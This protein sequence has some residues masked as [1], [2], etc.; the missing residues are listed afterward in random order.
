MQC[1]YLANWGKLDEHVADSRT[2]TMF[3]LTDVASVS[4]GPSHVVG[5]TNRPRR[6]DDDS[7]ESSRFDSSF[8]KADP[9]IHASSLSLSLL[10]IP[11]RLNQHMRKPQGARVRLSPRALMR[12]PISAIPGRCLSSLLLIAAVTL[13]C[14][15]L[16]RAAAPT[17]PPSWRPGPAIPDTSPI[18]TQLVSYSPPPHHHDHHH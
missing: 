18:A 14:V 9:S 12:P 10:C 16:Y 15:V 7:S 5:S 2:C 13:P 17:S 11:Y 6:R 1:S 4:Q 8:P 3:R